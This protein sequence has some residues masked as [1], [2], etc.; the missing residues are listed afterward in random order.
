MPRIDTRLEQLGIALPEPAAPVASYVPYVEHAGMLTVSGQISFGA[1]GLVTGRLG[2][3]LSLE[4]GI[5]AARLCGLMLLAQARAALGD[6]DRV[7]RVVRLGGFVASAPHFTDQ[8]K[9]VNGASDLML[10][11]FGEAGRHARAAVGAAALPLGAS[12]EVEGLF[13]VRP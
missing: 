12:V 5:A 10:D 8:P 2:D 11:V 1:D 4:D 6:L 3:E 9:V 13:A 7:E